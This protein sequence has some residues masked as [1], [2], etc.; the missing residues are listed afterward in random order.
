MADLEPLSEPTLYRKYRP[1]SFADVVGQEHVVRVLQ[2]AALEKKVAHAYLFSGAR[3][4]GKTTVARILAK[5][6]NCERPKAGEPCNR[7]TACRAVA[8]GAHLDLIEI[9]AAS[10]RGI[11]DIRGLKERIALQPAHGHWKVYI[12]DEVHML[13]K[14]AFNALLKTLEEPPAHA[15]FVLATTELEKVPETIRSRCQT[16]LFRRAPVTLLVERLQGIAKAE[17]LRVTPEALHLIA[18][19]AGGCFRDA[20][21]LLALVAG[22]ADGEIAAEIV[23]EL[24]GLTSVNAVQDFVDA[25]VA[26]D[27]A[28]ALKIVRALVERGA[29]PAAFLETLTRY[30]R[31]AATAAVAG[32][33]AESYAPREE[34]R[35]QALA[36]AVVLADLVALLRA[37]LRAKYEQRD[38][39]FPELPIELLVLEWC[40]QVKTDEER[41]TGKRTLAAQRAAEIAPAKIQAPREEMPKTGANPASASV[42]SPPSPVSYDK[43]VE[44]WPA[45]VRAAA[46]LHPLLRPMLR[47][48]LPLGTRGGTLYVMSAHGLAHDRLK[49]PKL[50][51]ALEEQL[52]IIM[53]EKL[54]L[55]LV[56]ER[57]LPVL[58]LT[59]PP[60]DVRARLAGAITAAEKT[61]PAGDGAV[62]DALSL[63]GGEV[64]ESGHP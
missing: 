6:L 4:T 35:L 28:S 63:F 42:I 14:E 25:L 21:S 47:E 53:G 43:L 60:D 64:V 36:K 38:S 19:S 26:S 24:F 20:E 46:S 15:L 41:T 30:L 59:L 54:V 48:A 56:R 12:V 45:I 51:H 2:R 10:H 32:A 9:D 13:T 11:E 50:R 57:D 34:E 52:E 49:D 44:R 31:A 8:A 23:S 7:C 18:S 1:Q 55:K 17:K 29:S 33:H 58:N 22:A 37:A 40:G 27:G 61:A 62:A 3:G 39:A 16:F 5:M